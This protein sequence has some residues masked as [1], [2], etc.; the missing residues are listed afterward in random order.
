MN[1]FCRLS[2]LFKPIPIWWPR[3]V[4][5]SIHSVCIGEKG[6]KGVIMVPSKRGFVYN[7]GW[8]SSF[9]RSWEKTFTP[10]AWGVNH[11]VEWRRDSPSTDFIAFESRNIKSTEHS[12]C[13]GEK[14]EKGVIMVPSKRGFV[15]NRGCLRSDFLLVS[16]FSKLYVR[17]M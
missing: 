16:F 17:R 10:E 9:L 8:F 12:V 14:G 11:G 2:F 4:S 1:I 3:L 13:I 5:N 15:Y 6:E 7:R